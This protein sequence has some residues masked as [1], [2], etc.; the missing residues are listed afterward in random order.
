MTEALDL[1]PRLVLHPPGGA[2]VLLVDPTSP[3]TGTVTFPLLG[4]V[5]Y[6]ITYGFPASTVTLHFPVG[7]VDIPVD[8][9]TGSGGGTVPIPG[10]GDVPYELVLGPPQI[11]ASDLFGAGWSNWLLPIGIG[12]VAFVML[13]G[14]R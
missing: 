4:A 9:F 2:V 11:T 12:V 10:L 5:P 14:R 6:S 8:P 7:D 13:R 1:R 3:V